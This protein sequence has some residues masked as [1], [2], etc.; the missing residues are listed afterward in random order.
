MGKIRLILSVLAI[1]A[2]TMSFASASEKKPGK[3]SAGHD[4]TS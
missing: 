4:R 2:M 3:S 1:T